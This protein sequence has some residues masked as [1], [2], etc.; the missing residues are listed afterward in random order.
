MCALRFND[1]PA[2]QQGV[3]GESVIARWL[4]ARGDTVLPVYEKE[5]DDGK[6]P[7]LFASNQTLI[8][9]DMLVFSNI[10]ARPVCWVEAKHKS[11]FSWYRI[12]GCWTTGIDLRHYNDYCAIGE[13]FPHP[14]YLFFLHSKDRDPNPKYASSPWPCPTGLYAQRLDVLRTKESHRSDAWARGMVYWGVDTLIRL[15]SLDEIKAKLGA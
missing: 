13:T 15:A 1:L 11:V 5:I 8:A 12:G 3:L 14:V 10:P 7:R 9:P 2:T 4:R 6:G